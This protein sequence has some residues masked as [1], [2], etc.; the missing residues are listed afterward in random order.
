MDHFVCIWSVALPNPVHAIT[1]S[2]GHGV[3]LDLL[4]IFMVDWQKPESTCPSGV[5]E[6]CRVQA[7]TIYSL[8]AHGWPPMASQ[9][10]S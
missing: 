3:K 9:F 5:E 6:D 10:R 4:C 8:C 1:D 7:M 2:G